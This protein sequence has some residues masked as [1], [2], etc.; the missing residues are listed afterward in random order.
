MTMGTS[1]DTPATTSDVRHDPATPVQGERAVT[2]AFA[3]GP[4]RR[5]DV[6]HS[7]VATWRFGNGPDVVMIH[8]WPLHGATFRRIIPRLSSDF[9][10]HVLDLP[11][12]GQT[13]WG[14]DAPIDLASH[15]AT[16]RLVTD[17]LGLGRHALLAHDS[18]GAIARLVAADD[19]RVA[20][21][22]LGNTEIPGHRPPVL[23]LICAAARLPGGPAAFTAMMRSRWMR[24]S[25]LGFRG[26]F[27]DPAYVEG[28]FGDLFVRP[29]LA[30]KRAA[31]GQ[32]GLVR[33]LDFAVLDG[34]REQHR[35]IRGPALLIWG[36]RDPF[37]PIDKARRMLG[38]FGGGA[39]LVEIPE[40]KLFA[41]EDHPEAFAAHA[42]RFLATLL[43][44][45]SGSGSD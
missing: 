25:S 38:Q 19:S 31:E 6:G 22:V 29:L 15:A 7:R 11:G 27:T 3:R 40:A 9:T 30:S 5:I 39:E 35:R 16:V 23:E 32:F 43:P 17:A 26:C 45:R 24:Q 42:A 4:D 18:G 20:G 37:F 13:E 12:T 44:A 8:G 34:L 2:A 28:E 36:P 1:S 14:A 21:L 10:L 41:H 33:H